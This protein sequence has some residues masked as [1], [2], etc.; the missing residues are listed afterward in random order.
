M[1]RK[2]F[3]AENYRQSF[4]L[5]KELP[6][7]FICLWYLIY[8]LKRNKNAYSLALLQVKELIFQ[9]AKIAFE[10][11][12]ITLKLLTTCRNMM[13]EV[14]QPHLPLHS[15]GLGIITSHV[16]QSASLDHAFLKVRLYAWLL[17]LLE[18]PLPTQG[19]KLGKYVFVLNFLF[20]FY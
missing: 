18:F 10:Y 15:N 16:C 3:T 11:K 5:E 8:Y 20:P 17:P 19:I 12:H 1:A 13:C 2:T 9:S 4:V 14:M 6:P 7:F